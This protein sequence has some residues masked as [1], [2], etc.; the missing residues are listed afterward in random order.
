[1]WA[2]HPFIAR[3]A[4]GKRLME[5][6]R[7]PEIQKIAWDM[8]GFRSGLPGVQSNPKDAPIAGIPE[9]IDSVVDMPAPAVM[10]A[11]LKAIAD[12]V[13]RP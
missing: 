9:H 1:V 3:T 5:A 4:N 10:E 12:G 8:H 11:I 13:K 6:L 7:D 2:S